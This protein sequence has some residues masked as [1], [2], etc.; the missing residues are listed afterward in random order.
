MDE[1]IVGDNGGADEGDAG[2]N[3]AL[4]DTGNDSGEYCT[5]IGLDHDHGHYKDN[6]HHRDAD[7]QQLFQGLDRVADVDDHQ[8]AAAPDGS[9]NIG[10]D[11]GDGGEANRG[12]GEVAAHVRESA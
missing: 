9:D 3:G 11:P 5:Q 1:H 7:G 6:G 8:D 10:G 2:H 12:A 4:G